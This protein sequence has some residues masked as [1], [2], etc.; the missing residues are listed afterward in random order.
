ME[1]LTRNPFV[2][3]IYAYCG[4]SG[5]FEFA[6]GGDIADALW[7]RDPI[8]RRRKY[9]ATSRLQR[10]HIGKRIP[11]NERLATLFS[12]DSTVIQEHKQPWG[13]PLFTMSTKKGEPQSPIPTFRHLSLFALVTSTS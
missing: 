2:V 5:V 11:S 4:N 3:D 12:H 1:R 9:G 7:P 8:T 6:D 13:W 10:L